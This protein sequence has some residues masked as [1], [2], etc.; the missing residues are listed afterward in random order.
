MV[1]SGCV[2]LELVFSQ[3][4]ERWAAVLLLHLMEAL[5]STLVFMDESDTVTSGGCTAA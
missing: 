1:K 4:M 2:Q 5:L 3:I